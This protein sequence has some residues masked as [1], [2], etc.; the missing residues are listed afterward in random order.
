MPK[1]NLCDNPTKDVLQK[2]S[3]TKCEGTAKAFIVNSNEINAWLKS[4]R[5]AKK[6]GLLQP[7]QQC[8]ICQTFKIILRECSIQSKR[9][10]NNDPG[11]TAASS[12]S[13]S[14]SQTQPQQSKYDSFI[15]DIVSNDE[16]SLM[17]NLPFFKQKF[18]KLSFKQKKY[19]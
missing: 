18:S 11:T 2:Y 1:K 6:A 10:N 13:S 4:H 19:A 14:S 5:T 3:H 12:S 8:Q 17:K 16:D 15:N 7:N 9:S